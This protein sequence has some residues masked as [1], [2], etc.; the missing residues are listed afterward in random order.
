[1]KRLELYRQESCH[2]GRSLP[3]Y[4]DVRQRLPIK[5]RPVHPARGAD[6]PDDP[7]RSQHRVPG[8]GDEGVGVVS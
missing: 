3:G 1:M 8:Y 5:L 4:A 7:G 2:G 6:D